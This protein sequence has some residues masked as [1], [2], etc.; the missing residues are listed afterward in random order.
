MAIDYD[1]LNQAY[2]IMRT[3]KEEFLR[4][5]ITKTELDAQLDKVKADI[6]VILGFSP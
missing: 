4:D 1:K 6:R 5:T 3:L 2:A